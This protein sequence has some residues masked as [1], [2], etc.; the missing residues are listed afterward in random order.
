MLS[1][2]TFLV[3]GLLAGLIAGIVAFGVAYVVGEPPV[4]AAI[5]LEEAAGHTH[6]ETTTAHSHDE[7]TAVVSRA[8]QA[9][10]GLL[11]ATVVAGTT[12]GGLMG[13]L[14]ALALGRLG[15]LGIRGSTLAVA[16]VGF[17]TLYAAPF[18][19][20]PPNPPA[21]GQGETIGYRTALYFVM[22]AISLI[23]GLAAVLVGRRLSARW[24]SW[25]ATLASIAGYGATVIIVAAL[26]PAYDELPANFPASVL[27]DFRLA[28]FGVQLSL[29]AVLAVV[30]AEL[31]VR[32]ARTATAPPAARA[33]A[34]L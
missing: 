12:L 33:T 14:S 21:V 23:A 22:L 11:T 29:W 30:L 1:A 3:R 15:G 19:V 31:S 34:S 8:L 28:S 16:G 9:T 5:G 26:L 24:G 13:V 2:R 4:N 32:A 27:Y 7:E 18:L 6:D 25:Y 20:Y 17:T 10:A